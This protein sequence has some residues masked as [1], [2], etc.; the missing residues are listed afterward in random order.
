[1]TIFYKKINLLISKKVK[2]KKINMLLTGGQTA[3]GL[4]KYWQKNNYFLKNKN[5]NFFLSDERIVST[6]QKNSNYN[7]LKKNLFFNDG[8]IKYRFFTFFYDKKKM[9]TQIKKYENVL[10]KY[11]DIAILSSGNDGHVASIFSNNKNQLD[12]NKKIV[13]S[14]AINK[15]IKRI[16]LS[17]KFIKKT[18]II[19]IMFK[20][21]K[22]GKIAAE[23]RINP[24]NSKFIIS[25]F[26][27]SYWIFDKKAHT[28]YRKKLLNKNLKN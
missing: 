17:L 23:T 10:P 18:K 28:A 14:Y 24:K 16:T 3:K 21:T 11:F 2:K 5:I 1:M 25:N 22:K 27:K 4:Y 15:P 13:F 26:L 9:K 8:S 6:N 20:G 19:I 12:T 7:A